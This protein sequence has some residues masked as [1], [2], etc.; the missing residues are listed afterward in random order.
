MKIEQVVT[1]D[2]GALD[3]I[4]EIDCHQYAKEYDPT[5]AYRVDKAYGEKK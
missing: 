2:D 3:E 5:C 4:H 1:N